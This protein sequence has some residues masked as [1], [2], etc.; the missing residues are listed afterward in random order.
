MVRTSMKRKRAANLAPPIY[1]ADDE[2]EFDFIPSPKQAS[3]PIRIGFES[4]VNTLST[5]K[6]AVCSISDDVAPAKRQSSL[7]SFFSKE[8]RAKPQS[9]QK[10]AN[11]CSTS[12]ESRKKSNNT[13]VSS[14]G[15]NEN[16]QYNLAKTPM[17]PASVRCSTS[18]QKTQKK[19]NSLTQVYIDCGQKKFGQILCSKCGT[20]YVPGVGE[21]ETEHNK[22]CEA[23]ALGIPCH[24][25]TIKGGKKIGVTKMCG[26]EGTIVSWR[27]STRKAKVKS[28][29]LGSISDIHH[30][31]SPSQ[32][33]LL[34]KMISKDLG[35][36]EETTLNHLTKEMVFLCIGKP[37]NQASIKVKSGTSSNKYRIV[38]VATVQL[39]GKVPAYRML[40]PNERS[41]TPSTNAK[42]G[43]G[44]LWTHPAC[45]KKGI[46]TKL[47]HAAR[48][49][50]FF[51]MR[52]ARQDVAFSNPTQAGYNFAFRYINYND[53]NQNV[54]EDHLLGP[55]V[56][57]MGL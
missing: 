26:N 6:T 15:N 56:Y 11:D 35:T 32:W 31:D 52:V 33:P 44:L 27:P 43:I 53:I 2:S 8:T 19:Q 3:S 20:L 10:Q 34:A 1:T 41:L 7:L 4:P 50:S 29:V 25:G 46:A 51:G 49:H 39:L 30:S 38:G 37:P 13:L 57:E 24:R 16:R 55:L 5:G 12:G 40:S 14:S 21:D 47:V 18:N 22:M 48:E 9:K 45:R 42:L 23:F 17:H 36:L 54:G 28:E